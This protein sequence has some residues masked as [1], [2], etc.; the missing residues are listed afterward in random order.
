MIN[1]IRVSTVRAGIAV[2]LC[3]AG[4]LPAAAQNEAALKS[5]FEGKRVTLKIDMPGTADGVDVQSGHRQLE[6]DANKQQP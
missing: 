2:A 6:D 3:A 4:A 1:A 5:F